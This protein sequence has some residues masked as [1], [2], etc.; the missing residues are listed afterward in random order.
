MEP[1]KA[2]RSERNVKKKKT[3]GGDIMFLDFKLHYKTVIMRTVRHWHKNRHIDQ[4]N[5]IENPEMTLN[6]M[7]N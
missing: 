5:R 4:W 7:V 2:P 3:K 6:S 1:E